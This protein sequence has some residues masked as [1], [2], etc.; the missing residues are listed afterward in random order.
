MPSVSRTRRPKPSYYTCLFLHKFSVGHFL[1]ARDDTINI[2]PRFKVMCVHGDEA[3]L[4]G[5]GA[6]EAL[7]SLNVEDL[8]P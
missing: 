4:F 6:I 7:L 5:D 3:A 2:Q 1:A 8:E